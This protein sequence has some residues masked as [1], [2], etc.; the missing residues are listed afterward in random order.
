MFVQ[1][2]NFFL[3][4]LNEKGI[5]LGM[6]NCVVIKIYLEIF[7]EFIDF[8]N[9][10]DLLIK[11]LE[12]LI[13]S[14][15]F[16]LRLLVIFIVINDGIYIIFDFFIWLNISSFIELFFLYKGRYVVIE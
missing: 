16:D 14:I 7:D 6:Y 1:F 13:M 15:V 12:V 5:I 11:L 4:F 10:F 3:G 2:E 8:F 9:V